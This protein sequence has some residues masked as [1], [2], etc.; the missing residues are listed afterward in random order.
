[1]SIAWALARRVA[2]GQLVAVELA[3]ALLLAGAVAGP[4]WLAVLAPVA[5]ALVLGAFGR[6]NGR[7]AYRWLALRLRVRRGLPAGS[8]TA[9]LLRLLDPT[10][11]V[12]SVD[13]DG[14]P[15]G[16]VLDAY[17]LTAVLELGDPAA[18]LADAAVQA[19]PIQAPPGTWLRLLLT[20]AP[21]PAPRAGGAAPAT[22]YRHLTES[23]VPAMRRAF[24]SVHVDIDAGER[25]LA[26]AVRKVGRT[27]RR[28]GVPYRPLGPDGVLR[29]LGELAHHDAGHP[30]REDWSTVELGG[31]RQVSFRLSGGPVAVDRLLGLPADA[32]TVAV[33]KEIVVRVAAQNL[34]GVLTSLQRLLAASGTTAH[35]L[36]GSHLAGLATTLPLGGRASG[37]A[38]VQAP[39]LGTAGLMLGLNRHGEPTAVR[40]FR[41]EPTRVVLVGGLRLAQLVV[42]RTLALGAHVVVRTGRPHAWEPFQRAIGDSPLFGPVEPDQPASPLRPHLVV[43][44]SGPPAAPA[45]PSNEAAWRATLLVRDEL[46]AADA[47]ALARADLVLLQ[48]LTAAE[49][50]LAGGALGLGGSTEWLTRIRSDM[51]GVV[52]P[53]RGVRWALLSPTPIEEQVI[54]AIAR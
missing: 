27:L 13:V 8:G 16:M 3:L 15:V 40:L 10:S 4:A 32:T 23:R 28:A 19:P 7:W 34:P 48:P 21:A 25:A 30:V 26:G 41:P 12:D 5:V 31:L 22:S 2:P 39:P 38:D 9:A 37:T 35:R 20:S 52:L 18:V 42:L 53:R 29:V 14:V 50:A 33:G 6:V 36:D 49:A 54:G 51:V 43:V 11:T 46:G 1:V 45:V 44:D 17:T 24:V 47:D